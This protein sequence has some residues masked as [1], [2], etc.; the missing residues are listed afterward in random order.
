MLSLKQEQMDMFK[1][2]PSFYSSDLSSYDHLNR[3]GLRNVETAQPAHAP[4][5]YLAAPDDTWKVYQQ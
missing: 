5:D 2:S 3:A 1:A 4:P